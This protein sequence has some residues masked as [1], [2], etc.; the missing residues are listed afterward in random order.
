[1][2]NKKT[3]LLI[4][5][6]VLVFLMGF[7]FHTYS[8]SMRSVGEGSMT[9]IREDSP[10]FKYINPLLFVSN[11]E[12]KYPILNPLKNKLAKF[13]SQKVSD[14]S[15]QNISVYVREMDTGRWT[16]V[17]EDDLYA[18]ASMLKIVTLMAYL[19]VASDDSRL[20]ARKYY[21]DYQ[22]N[23]SQFYKPV[24]LKTGY[25]SGLVLLQQMIVYSD[26]IAMDL[27]EQENVSSIIEL[28]KD[29]KLPSPIGSPDN[30]MSPRA[31]SRFLRTLYNAT[32][33]SRTYSEQALKLLTYTN[34]ENGL[35]KGVPQTI[36]IAHKFGEHTA[37][38][39]GE[40]KYRELHD[41]GIVYH[42]KEPYLLCVM[43]KGQDFSKLEE[44]IG[45]ISKIVL[46]YQEDFYDK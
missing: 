1:M 21:Y 13:V 23:N 32:Y 22:D 41:C 36:D 45:G 44:V 19:K 9:Q 31:Y 7:L 20:L 39:E 24:S 33:L 30:F 17:N 11:T 15:A 40:I 5:S 14:G 29:L 28:Y 12:E 10:E 18:P 46:D 3:L 26:N 4:I 43:T 6:F 37:L 2:N 25:Y 35:R 34:F 16:G 27:I 42:P 8:S 38:Q